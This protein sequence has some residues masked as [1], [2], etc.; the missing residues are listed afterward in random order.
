MLVLYLFIFFIISYRAEKLEKVYIFPLDIYNYRY[1][2]T[3][4]QRTNTAQG[5]CFM[6]I[7]YTYIYVYIGPSHVKNNRII[8]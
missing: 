4:A 3:L 6:L 8:C 1:G 5:Q 7:P 2:S